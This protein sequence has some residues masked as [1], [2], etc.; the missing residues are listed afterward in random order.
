MESPI[1]LEAQ[2]DK[3]GK[4]AFEMRFRDPAL[5]VQ[6][7]LE[8][9]QTAEKVSEA[10]RSLRNQIGRLKLILSSLYIR[11]IAFDKSLSNALDAYSIYEQIDLTSGMARSQNAIGLANLH[12]GTYAE[13]LDNLLKALRMANER[14][15]DAL[16]AT[17]LNNLGLLYIR[18]EEYPQALNY[19]KESLELASSLNDREIEADMLENI[20]VAYLNLGKYS[21]A[22]SH[23]QRGI[24]L[25]QRSQNRY[26]EAKALSTA[27]EIYAAM[28]HSI[29]AL[30][31]YQKSLEI[32]DEIEYI[33]GKANAHLLIG[34]LEFQQSELDDALH[35]LMQALE[36]AEKGQDTSLVYRAHLQL[37]QIY[38]EME[39]YQMALSHFE[40]FHQIKE[41]VFNEDMTTKIKSLEIMHRVRETQQDSEIYRLRNVELTR[42]IEERK[43][44]QSKL[45]KIATLD[46]LTGIF[47]RRHFFELTQQELNRSRRYNR[48]LSVIML[49]I[50]HFKQVND[51]FGHLVGDRVLVEVA[52]RIQKALRRVD[53]ACRYGGEEFAVLLPETTLTQA[54]MVATR[55]WRLVT[56]QPTVSGEL[57]LKIT[58]SVGVATYHHDGIIAVDTL[59]DRA[60]KAM[61]V[62]KQT[63]RNRVV[64]YSEDMNGEGIPDARPDAG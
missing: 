24:V 57:K 27:G 32:C 19:L 33:Q 6:T 49:D 30:R 14:E 52:R 54:E 46:P 10:P 29:E 41:S 50:D 42:E 38:R 3:V 34:N 13:A 61:Y 31:Y 37:S 40:A 62:A 63:G 47:N 2:L 43:K 11:L 45:E 58:V 15:D 25:Y 36:N 59:L 7:C 18:M 20:C 48:P 22:L 60:D 35:H 16:K 9:I 5:A 51:R 53:Q 44:V 55:L 28:G 23:S 39:D 56:K 1:E 8:A 21:D 4:E 26:G 64:V 12:L 17:V